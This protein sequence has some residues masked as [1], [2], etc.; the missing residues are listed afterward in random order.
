MLW[1]WEKKHSYGK[2]AIAKMINNKSE[3]VTRAF[4][5]HFAMFTEKDPESFK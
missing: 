5:C 3:Q 1:K 2:D 4:V